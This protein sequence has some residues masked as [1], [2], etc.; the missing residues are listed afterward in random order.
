[1]DA[2]S[3]N[4]GLC[5]ELDCGRTYR[6]KPRKVKAIIKTHLKVC[7]VCNKDCLEKFEFDTKAVKEDLARKYNNGIQKSI[8]FSSAPH[9]NKLSD[10]MTIDK[11]LTEKHPNLKGKARNRKMYELNKKI[12]EK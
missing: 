7:S 12:K 6:G 10:N 11:Y 3:I 4:L 9:P 1:M 5:I 8:G 2:N